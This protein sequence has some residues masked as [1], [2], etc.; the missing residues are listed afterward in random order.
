MCFGAQLLKQMFPS[1]SLDSSF[2]TVAQPYIRS[3][4][5]TLETEILSFMGELEQ[6][7]TNPDRPSLLLPKPFYIYARFLVNALVS[8]S[9]FNTRQFTP[10][11][12]ALSVKIQPFFNEYR[13]FIPITAQEVQQI[14]TVFPTLSFHATLTFSNPQPVP[15]SSE[16]RTAPKQRS[17]RR[18]PQS[19]KY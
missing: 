10:S 15:S 2:L 12:Q 8:L 7:M 4:F 13:D 5:S 18:P 1:S 9:H 11:L 14:S 16:P 3:Y 19:T 17:L 6:F